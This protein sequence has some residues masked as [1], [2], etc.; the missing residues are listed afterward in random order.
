[1]ETEVRIIA[2]K[3]EQL[4]DKGE[5]SFAFTIVIPSSS[6]PFE[7]CHYGRVYHKLYAIAKG[8]GAMNGNVEA[9]KDIYLVVNP[10]E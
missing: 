8:S 4:F 3:E 7:R 6:A 1:M 10:A 2:L 9:E 5:H